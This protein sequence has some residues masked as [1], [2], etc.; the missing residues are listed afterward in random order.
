MSEPVR[1]RDADL[2]DTTMPD[3]DHPVGMRLLFREP[4]RTALWAV[5]FPEGFTREAGGWY[6]VIEEI[7]VIQG[8]LTMSGLQY[9]AGTY[10]FV[11]SGYVREATSARH[12]ALAIARFSGPALWNRGTSH[13][14]ASAIAV[15]SNVRWQD[16]ALVAGPFGPGRKLTV[17]DSSELWAVDGMQPGL[18]PS[19]AIVVAV[20][21]REAY[22]IKAGGRVPS[23]EGTVFAWCQHDNSRDPADT[24]PSIREEQR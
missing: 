23:L 19:E 16:L 4:D 6:D 24:V 1:F 18:A 9:P 2:T 13:A 17:S 11:P 8:E 10:A 3:A 7:L 14:A 21:Q 5:Q 12:G 20:E 15:A 22:R